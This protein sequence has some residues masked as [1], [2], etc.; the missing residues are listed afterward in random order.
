MR[1]GHSNRHAFRHADLS[2]VCRPLPR[3]LAAAQEGFPGPPPGA[4]GRSRQAQQV[5]GLRLRGQPCTVR[6]SFVAVDDI[7]GE[8]YVDF[9]DWYRNQKHPMERVYVSRT[10]NEL[11]AD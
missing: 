8:W 5:S 3:A 4:G 10:D 7:A 11:S 2:R 6:R 9:M 1:R